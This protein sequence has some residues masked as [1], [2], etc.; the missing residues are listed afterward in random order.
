VDQIVDQMSKLTARKVETAKPGKHDA[1]RPG[2][3]EAGEPKE[4]KLGDGGGLQL[5]VSVSGAKKWVLRFAHNG[6]PRELGLGGYPTVSLAD[7]RDMALTARKQIAAGLDPI[8]ARKA[9]QAVPTFG[10]LADEVV[11]DLAPSFRNVKDRAAW[12]M[13]LS[14]YAAPL[15][16]KPV[17]RIETADVLAV[18]RPHWK[19]RRETASR[20]R[21]RIERVLNVAKAKGFRSGENPAAWRG[22]L[23]NLLSKRSHLT[24]GHHAAMSYSELPSFMEK[25]RV[26]EGVTALALEFSILTAGR[27]GEVL[28]A[29]WSEIDL[30]AAVW[31]LPPE[32]MKAGREHRVP[33][34]EAAMA[35]LVQM[36]SGRVSAHVFPGQRAGKPLAPIALEAVLRRMKI[37]TAT[38][39]GFRSTFRDW[40]GNETHFPRELAEHALAHALGD[41]AEQAYRRGD[42]LERRRAMMAAWASYCSSSAT[43]S[44]VVPLRAVTR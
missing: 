26:R 29:L 37:D 40:L 5:V 8:A 33:L 23:E 19:D 35:I 18:L 39:H 42:A 14:K 17:D 2:K 34:S 3:H 13:T 41:R 43:D 20:L 38:V 4:A 7:A 44:N 27:T 9:D 6:K 15:R 32:R 1:A 36:R 22:H 25:L 16:D 11:A 28:G 24:R 30:D 10:A 21:G 12:S 31:T